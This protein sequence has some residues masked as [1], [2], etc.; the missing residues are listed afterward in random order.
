MLNHHL[1][2]C[3]PLLIKNLKLNSKTGLYLS[4]WKEANIPPVHKNGPRDD[5]LNYRPISLLPIVSKIQ[6]KCV[7]RKLVPHITDILHSAQYGFQAR[8]SCA[9]QLVEVFHDI[10]SV[11]DKGKETDI[12]Y[13]DFSKAFGSVCHARLLWKLMHI[14]VSGPLLHINGVILRGLK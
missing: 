14:G 2:L 3:L 13:L 11:L 8:V 1:R 4:E 6:E 12:M 9:S 10:A 5:V 7:A